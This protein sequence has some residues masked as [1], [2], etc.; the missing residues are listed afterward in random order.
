MRTV[1][2]FGLF[3]TSLSLLSLS[4]TLTTLHAADSKTTSS[5]NPMRV[6]IGTYTTHG[7]QGIYELELDP[8]TGKLSQPQ[9]AGETINP[10]FLALAP[11]GKFLYSVS[12]STG[13]GGGKKA[14]AINAFAID[15][16]TGKL[17]L[18]NQ[19]SSKGQGPCH[20]TVDHS[21]KFALTT[22]YNSGSVAVLPINSDGSLSE[23]C[24]FDQHEGKG[25]N[26]SRQEGPHA[27]SVNMDP[28][29]QF[30]IVCDLGLDKVFIYRLEPDGKL[31]PND[32]PTVSVA[33]G[34]GPRHFTFHPNG[35]VAYLINEMGGTINVFD[36][37]AAKGTLKEIQTISTL[38]DGLKAPNNTTAEVQL[39]PNGMFLYGSNRGHDTIAM[40]S[41]DPATGKLTSLGEVPSG[42]KT[43]RSFAIDPTGTWLL[44]A[45]QSTDNVCVFHIDPA[46]GKLEQTE[47]SVKIGSPVCVKFYKP[48]K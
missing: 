23:A 41:V 48:G 33:P 18:L 5:S 15:P 16:A 44:A 45:H 12:E 14:G 47:N 28:T 19:Q 31:T 30:A 38:P 21:G 11:N 29:N 9:L 26:K 25:P 39:T 43:P 1:S 32:P 3:F 35:K 27:H 6:Y 7:S 36:W 40:F 24:A 8:T 13:N 37:N 4:A 34:S 2:T 42:G 46:T 10:S 20:V 17:T 22:N